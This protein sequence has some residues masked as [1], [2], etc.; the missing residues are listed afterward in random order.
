MAIFSPI[1]KNS[2]HLAVILSFMHT[3]THTHPVYKLNDIDSEN[4]I[5]VRKK[6]KRDVERVIVR[7]KEDNSR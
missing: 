4:Y 7:F 5:I 2:K 1:N 6:I 3:H